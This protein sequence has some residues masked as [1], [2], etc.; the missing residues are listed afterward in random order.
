MHAEMSIRFSCDHSVDFVRSMIPHHKGAVAMC[1]VLTT[2]VRA[3]DDAY[4][5]DSLF[6]GPTP[7]PRKKPKF[8]NFAKNSLNLK[9]ARRAENGRLVGGAT[10]E[11]L[12]FAR[13]HS[14]ARKPDRSGSEQEARLAWLSS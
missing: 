6:I 5:V 10:A 11:R 12:R 9:A 14:T 3:E 2:R 4:L 1:E 13:V 8:V 7:C